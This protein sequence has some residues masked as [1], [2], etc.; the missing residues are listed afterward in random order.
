LAAG[1]YEGGEPD[2]NSRTRVVQSIEHQNSLLKAKK[3]TRVKAFLYRTTVGTSGT[4]Y[5]NIRNSSDSL[6]KTLDTVAV[7]SLN[8]TPGTPSEI[9]FEDPTNNY[10]LNVGDKIGIEFNGGSTT[11]QLGVLVREVT[12]N[13]DGSN[14]F[15]RKFDEV[16]YDD[17]EPVKDLCAVM[18]EGGFFFTPEPGSIPDPTPTNIKDLLYA[19]GNNAKSGFFETFLMEFRIYSKDI[20]LT[21]ASDL[22]N[23]RYSISPI[24][25]GEILMPFSLKC[26]T[27]DPV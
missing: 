25:N 3:I 2:L 18:D 10:P 9:T 13:Y 20:T 8:T 12:P 5:C 26:N 19:A 23:N 14:S 27:L 7:S 1:Y 21:N 17:S 4:V 24:G 15:I 16:D 11:D 6:I 22:Y